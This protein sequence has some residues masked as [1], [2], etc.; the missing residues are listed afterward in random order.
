[1]DFK[2][3]TDYLNLTTPIK[4]ETIVEPEIKSE[5]PKFYI[6]QEP[7]EEIFKWKISAP[8]FKISKKILRSGFVFVFLF[9]IFLVL[10]QDWV[11]LLVLLGLSFLVNLLL[12]NKD[13]REIKYIIYNNGFEY[14]ETFYLWE[15][16]NQFFYYDGT[17]DLLIIESKDVLP[18]R[19][20]VYFREEDREKIDSA[21]NKYISKNIIHP[22]DFY[23]YVIFKIKPYLNLSD[24]K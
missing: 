4:E 10:A 5:D 9:G 16:L 22:K 24:E 23:E 11:F 18:G 14:G 2:K 20:Y 15:Q 13:N 21:L 17:T 19:I 3:I 7:Q 8:S 12:N 1:M 6:K